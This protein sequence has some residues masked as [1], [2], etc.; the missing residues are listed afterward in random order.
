MA[1]SFLSGGSDSPTAT[2]VRSPVA[3]SP[4]ILVVGRPEGDLMPLAVPSPPVLV[5][6]S[7]SPVSPREITPVLLP[8]RPSSVRETPTAGAGN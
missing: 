3:A 5:I 2:P 8:T 7:P 6:S 4:V 1:C